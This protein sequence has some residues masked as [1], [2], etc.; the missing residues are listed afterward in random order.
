MTY[1]K[2]PEIEF[3]HDDFDLATLEDEIRVDERCQSLL[4]RFYQH[5]Q[6]IGKST[7]DASD[8]AY[9][10]DYYLRDYLVDARITLER[11]SVQFDLPAYRV[12]PRQPVFR[13]LDGH[14]AHH[15]VHFIAFSEQPLR[16]IGPI[17]PRNSAD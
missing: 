9:C 14:T 6:N 11:R 15:P 1:L 2:N 8:L 3:E 12:Q 16:Q 13:I 7:Q 4:K 5:L 10:A 17:L